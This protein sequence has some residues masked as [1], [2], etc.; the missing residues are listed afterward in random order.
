MSTPTY[1]HLPIFTY[2]STPTYLHLPV[3]THLSIPTYQYLLLMYFDIVDLI[4]LLHMLCC[5]VN[6]I[7]FYH[8]I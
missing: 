2:L 8:M 3:Y 5:D 1:L 6:V 4:L 7:L